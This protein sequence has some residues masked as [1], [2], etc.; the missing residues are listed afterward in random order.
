MP[1]NWNEIENDINN[2][3]LPVSRTPSRG[4]RTKQRKNKFMK[5]KFENILPS[6]KYVLQVFNRWTNSLFVGSVYSGLWTER[7]ETIDW[8]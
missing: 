8:K 1:L 7:I 2:K 5:I 4:V 6:S 3:Y